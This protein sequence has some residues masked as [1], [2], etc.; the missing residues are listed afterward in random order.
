MVIEYEN[1]M[2]GQ[3]IYDV[4]FI[5]Q[6]EARINKRMRAIWSHLS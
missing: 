6:A 3:P 4:V 1:I 5:V 2:L